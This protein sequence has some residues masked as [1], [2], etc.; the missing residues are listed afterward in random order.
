MIKQSNIFV[1]LQTLS[2]SASPYPVSGF[3]PLP[4][5]LQAV[6]ANVVFGQTSRRCQGSGICRV[7]MVQAGIDL[8]AVGTCCGRNPALIERNEQGRLRFKFPVASL[9]K[10]ME[11]QQFGRGYFCVDEDFRTPSWLLERLNCRQMYI[12]RGNYPVVRRK[13]Y[14]VIDF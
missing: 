12:R 14:W 4:Q 2:L 11:R 5:S 7:D 3:S 1:M 10:K 13:E 9:C 6:R 8:P